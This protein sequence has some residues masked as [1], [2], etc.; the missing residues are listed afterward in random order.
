M[1]RLP[2]CLALAGVLSTPAALACTGGALTAQDGGVVV[3][4]TLEFGQPL[5]SQIAVWPAGS[6]IEGSSNQ[7]A[8]LRYVSRYGFLGATVADDAGM[9]LDGLNEKGLNVGLF[10]F[11]GYAQYTPNQQ[12]SPSRTLAPVQLGTWILANFKSVDEVKAQINSVSVTP[13]VLGILGMVPDVH[14]KVQDASGKSVVIEPRGGRL[15]VHD[16][17]MRVLTNA[18]TFDWQTTNLSNYLTLSSAYPKAKR[19]GDLTLQPFGMGAG[20]FGLPGDFSPPSRFV[21]IS[22][23]TANAAPTPNGKAAVSSLFHILNNFDIPYG[24]AQPPAGTSEADPDYTTWTAVSDLKNLQFNWKTFGDQ[25]VKTLDL[26]QALAAAGNKPR[27]LPMG[28]QQ[29]T[30]VSPTTLIQLP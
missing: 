10:Y 27:L 4:R 21:R 24:V 9:I 20:A 17:P 2:L 25:R 29:P 5:D 26:R 14:F 12:A 7:G 30:A 3:G 11:P 13:Q 1:A 18:P 23:F 19:I 28:P 22:F 8:G 15:V 16:N 6:S